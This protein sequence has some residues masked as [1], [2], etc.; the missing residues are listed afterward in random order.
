M[1]SEESR[2]ARMGRRVP[3]LTCILFFFSVFQ[4]IQLPL[5]AHHADV[6]ED[7][8]VTGGT[9]PFVV[10]TDV[11][12]VE[13]DIRTFLEMNG[14]PVHEM[15][16]VVYTKVHAT[17]GDSREALV[18]VFI[19]PDDR[20][21]RDIFTSADVGATV[22]KS[23]LRKPWLSKD[24]YLVFIPGDVQSH[25]EKLHRW[26]T[27]FYKCAD[28][29]TDEVPLIRGA[30][31]VDFTS[32]NKHG[33]PEVVVEGRNGNSAIEDFSNVMFE[34]ANEI[35][36]PI[37]VKS[38]YESINYG[39]LD[40]ASHAAHNVF[41]DF[42]IPS[43]T[44]QRSNNRMLPRSAKLP[45]LLSTAEVVGK[46]LRAVSG[47]HHQLHHSTP[48]FLYGGNQKDISIGTYL[49]LFLYL[50]SP[51][52]VSL[53][54]VELLIRPVWLDLSMLGI[55]ISLPL[56]IALGP[57]VLNNWLGNIAYVFSIDFMIVV[58]SLMHIFVVIQATKQM[59]THFTED[60]KITK[61]YSAALER[62]YAVYL[63]AIMFLDWRLATSCALLTIP[64]LQTS[65]WMIANQKRNINIIYGFICVLLVG[66][67][68]ADDHNLD[69]L[70]ALPDLACMK[71]LFS[72]IRTT[73][74]E[75]AP[76]SLLPQCSD[77]RS[78]TCG[79]VRAFI[80]SLPVVILELIILSVM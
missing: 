76:R 19:L 46:H 42:A 27:S 77:E 47:I 58:V 70:K 54:N 41:L 26:L 20:R 15:D 1:E 45:T 10:K 28:C 67:I 6:E 14:L 55:A 8:I 75:A 78:I 62:T 57:Y 64:V 66:V 65:R 73:V 31:A 38:V 21:E 29:H 61:T 44:L 25:S 56:S 39:I 32:N 49:P 63:V 80:L 7:T 69:T 13:E 18:Y 43:F 48:H 79:A 12:I 5:Y 34:A 23:I 72:T 22:A 24:I 50:I 59:Q 68:L 2:L 11:V 33:F 3:L 17:R 71:G 74:H 4:L 35:G 16:G 40:S 30:C 9:S 53:V 52:A 36:Y 51:L 60:I 37:S